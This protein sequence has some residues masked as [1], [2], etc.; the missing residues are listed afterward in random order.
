[1]RRREF[2]VL[3]GGATATT[4]FAAH[5]QQG[6][7]MRRIGFL[8]AALPSERDL[9]H[10]YMDSPVTVGCKDKTMALL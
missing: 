8:R 10:S 9:R 2:I 3:L 5:A 6:E 7:R 1:M 4:P